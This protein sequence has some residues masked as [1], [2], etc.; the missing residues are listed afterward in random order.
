MCKMKNLI[1][2]CAV[3]LLVFTACKNE[4]VAKETK[5]EAVQ[6]ILAFDSFGAKITKD[7]ALNSDEMLAKYRD[8]KSR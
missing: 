7:A 3:T 6:E 1:K 8:L 5:Q 2:F 4:K